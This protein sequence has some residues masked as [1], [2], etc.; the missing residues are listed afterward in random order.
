MAILKKDIINDLKKSDAWKT[1]LAIAISLLPSK[2]NDEEY[3]TH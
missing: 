1:Q 3:A 2:D